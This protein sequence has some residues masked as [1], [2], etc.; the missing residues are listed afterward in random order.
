MLTAG[1]VV[2]CADCRLPRE[3]PDSWAFDRSDQIKVENANKM[4]DYKNT[5]DYRGRNQIHG[6]LIGL[7]R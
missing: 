7:T 6:P 5:A 2:F 3:K 1:F 4:Q